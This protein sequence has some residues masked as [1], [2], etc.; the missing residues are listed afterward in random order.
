MGICESKII[1]QYNVETHANPIIKEEL[2]ELY[3]YE[4]ALCKIK[5]EILING[6]LNQGI[7]TGFFCEINDN[8]IPF[9]KALFTNNHVLNENRI[10]INKEIKFEY[11][12]KI[13]II[14]ITEYRKVFTNKNLDYTCIEI[15]KEDKIKKFFNIDKAI[16]G[17]KKD[18]INK[19][20]FILQY[21]SGK[22]GHD[23]GKILKIEQNKIK[24]SV[25]TYFGSSGSPLIRRYNNNLIIGIHFAYSGKDKIKIKDNK[26]TYNMA[27]PFD[28]IIKNIKDQLFY[29]NNN[30]EYKNTIN[31]IY[32]K[33]ETSSCNIFGLK[34]V[35]NNKENI[36]LIINNKEC[37]L[38]EKYKLKDGL[39]YIQMIINN[40]MENLEYMFENV[41]SLK[42]IEELKYLNTEEVK[43]FSH[44]FSGC[45]S[46]SNIKPLENWNISNGNNFSYMFY[47]C[48]LLSDLKPL[49]N[50]NVS[51][52]NNFS[53][54]FS[55][56]PSLLNIKPLK[57]WN[58]SNG[59]NFS[60]MFSRCSL[61]LNIKPLENWNTSKG[62]NFSHMFSYCSL[63][64]DIKPLENWNVSNGKNFSW[65]FSGCSSLSD[66]NPLENW[67]VSK[68]NNFS[69][70]FSGCSSL[71]DIKGLEFWN[72]SSGYYFEYMFYECWSLSNI[73]PL[74][75]WNVSNGKYFSNIF[76]S[77]HSS[78]NLKTLDKWNL[79]E[80]I[81]MFVC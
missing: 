47:E 25:S 50:W 58:V 55:K 73:K 4:S 22:L 17:N 32:E 57:N 8:S 74:E 38:I 78:L 37:N 79:P 28:V 18:L 69:W 53:F 19:E 52:G 81:R 75:N 27:T 41:N 67:D 54:M 29:H 48:S 10:K 1:T 15:L 36:T 42:N 77:C 7:G 16:F 35:E 34:F 71:S 26:Y 46:L 63:L 2:D 40:K 65:M 49:E 80:S 21:P 51:N 59:K 39:N 24:H 68:G 43:N 64:S 20:I 12:K 61:L 13:K 9:K 62:N 56:C 5:F 66:I 14:K 3:S 72:V 44:M 6:E 33:D 60:S 31:L 30:I 70:M 76:R 11:L 45:S 23:A